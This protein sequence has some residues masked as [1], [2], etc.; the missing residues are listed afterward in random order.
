M[1]LK[2]RY[3]KNAATVVTQ[4][5]VDREDPAFKTPTKPIGSFMQKEEADS[6]KEE[7]L[8]IKEDAGRGYRRVVASPMPKE[9][10]ELGR[11]KKTYRFRLH[12]NRC[13]RRRY[14]G[15]QKRK[16]RFNR[17]SRSYR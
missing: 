5:L 9:I 14:S 7:I 15:A 1:N 3:Q 4:V 11:N 13:R 17:Y 2:T 10:I 12:R 8:N 16:R 6:V